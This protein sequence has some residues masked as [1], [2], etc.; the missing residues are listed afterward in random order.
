MFG[1]KLFPKHKN[2]ILNKSLVLNF[3]FISIEN[4]ISTYNDNHLLNLKLNLE[5]NM[6]SIKEKESNKLNCQYDLEKILHDLNKYYSLNSNSKLNNPIQSYKNNRIKFNYFKSNYSSVQNTLFT[7]MKRTFS[8]NFDFNSLFY[9]EEIPSNNKELELY[10]KKNTNNLNDIMNNL[11]Y[12]IG[13]GENFNFDI[14]SVALYLNKFSEYSDKKKKTINNELLEI[15][16][17]DNYSAINVKGFDDE[18]LLKLFANLHMAKLSEFDKDALQNKYFSLKEAN[19]IMAENNK[20]IFNLLY[21]FDIS[22]NK[23]QK[24]KKTLLIELRKNYE[25]LTIEELHFYNSCL[26]FHNS[27][28][29]SS[30]YEPLYK[31]LA[32]ILDLESK[33]KNYPLEQKLF[34]Y[35]PIPKLLSETKKLKNKK[36]TSNHSEKKIN[37]KEEESEAIITT[38]N[39][40]NSEEIYENSLAKIENFLIL[41]ANN[42]QINAE[43]LIP[44]LSNTYNYMEL[45]SEIFELFTDKL[46]NNL[47]ALSNDNYVELFFLLLQVSI[48][49]SYISP[50]R[51]KLAIQLYNSLLSLKTD[52]RIFLDIDKFYIYLNISR[53]NLINSY[54]KFLL[55]KKIKDLNLK[56]FDQFKKLVQVSIDLF[57][58]SVRDKEY[59]PNLLEDCLFSLNKILNS[60]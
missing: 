28:D 38:Q 26:I 31:R 37:E 19:K 34:N 33:N 30:F 11:S 27:K 4:I 12:I 46:Y 6:D 44:I 10:I 40:F 56:N 57:P 3:N 9:L 21:F 52:P 41:L 48:D 55:S 53:N 36:F 2:K 35:L 59:S 45:K 25:N 39:S 60:N 43:F 5:S 18:K 16:R 13:S 42:N 32:F 20:K 8:L 58:F 1:L 22:G 7:L 17:L 23:L 14:F 51:K 50:K 49:A 47:A 24:I 54:E 29:I 15:L